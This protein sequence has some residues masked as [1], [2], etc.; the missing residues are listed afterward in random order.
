M[1]RPLPPP[2]GRVALPHGAEAP[3]RVFVNGEERSEGVDWR[4]E[5]GTLVFTTPLRPRPDLGFWR[6]F[7]LSLG[8]GVYGDLKGDT[9]DVTFQRDGQ[10]RQA[11]LAIR[12]APAPV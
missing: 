2:V 7:T 1:S 3:I 10:L 6:S 12:E 9:L 11:N 4:V 8:I 5:D